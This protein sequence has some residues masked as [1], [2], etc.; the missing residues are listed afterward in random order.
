MLLISHGEEAEEASSVTSDLP[1]VLEQVALLLVLGLCPAQLV[2]VQ[3]LEELGVCGLTEQER[4]EGDSNLVTK[5]NHP[6]SSR[7]TNM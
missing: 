3:R 6:I 2:R 7:E 4:G 5:R 1:D